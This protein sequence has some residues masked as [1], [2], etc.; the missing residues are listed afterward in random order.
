VTRRR[1]A[2]LVPALLLLAFPLGL[3]AL[4]RATGGPAPA[5]GKKPLT[6]EAVYGEPP[7]VSRPASGIAWR[8]ARR[9]TFVTRDGSGPEAPETLWQVDA[10][11]GIKTT[12]LS[13]PELPAAGPDRKPMPLSLDR[14]RWN[15]AGT[16]ILLTAD[17][18]LW[19]RRFDA[20]PGEALKRLTRDPEP[21]E[22]AQFSPDGSRVA[23][24]KKN[25]L[26][27]VDVATGAEKRLTTTGS[28]HLLNGK[29]DWVYEEELANRRSGR[30]FEWAPDGKSIAYL[31]LD[32]NRVPEYPIV[33]DLPTDAKLTRQ[34]YPKA[35][36]PNPAPSVH[37]VDL[38][39]SETAS[40]Q[41]DP[42][43]VLIAPEFSWTPDATSVVF[44]QL[45]RVQTVL[46]FSLLP[47]AGGRPKLLLR[48]SDP[49]W[50]NHLEPPRFLKDGSGFLMVS[51]RTGFA[52]LYRYA[53]DGTLRNAVTRGGWMVDGPWDVDEKTGTAF[54]VSTEKDP[55]ERQVYS[56]RLDGTSERRLTVEEGTHGL[57]LS[58]GGRWFVSTFS[59]L[60]TP[61][62][63]FLR[64]A[65]GSVAALLDEPANRLAEYELP[66]TEL[67]SFRGTDGTLFYTSLT[68]PP[69]FDPARKYPVLVYVYGG[70]HAQEVRNAWARPSVDTVLA[71]KGIL[72]WTMD[73]RGS[74]GRGHAFET[75]VLRNLGTRELADQLEGTAE[76]KKRPYVDG[77]RI[78]IH[79]WSYGGYLTLFAA[80]HAGELF[81]SAAAGAPV[82]DW[83]FYDSI[84]TERYMKLP[85][86]NVEGY[87]ASS[88]VEAAG[89]L[90]TRLLIL[91]GT[92]D[93]NVH[94]QNTMVFADALMKARKDYDFVPLPRQPHGPRDPAAR[95]Y[96][97]QRIAELFEETLLN[98]PLKTPREA[99]RERA[100]GL[101]ES[102]DDV[103]KFSMIG[104]LSRR[105]R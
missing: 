95:L 35:G 97:N 87:K 90:G 69:G 92:S 17:S 10:E 79:G 4:T 82:T 25:D 80:T 6:L 24:V 5:A 32:E 42:D 29:L 41:P 72:V 83:K 57:V 37:V 104:N 20:A 13:K 22:W 85:K 63:T 14:Y 94:L 18:D 48:E 43:D 77:S 93:D 102:C 81:R 53:M 45:D 2:G 64:K 86:D 67:G 3:P 91:H 62:K 38:D 34:R 15:S 50:I 47:R 16:A 89:K 23:Y 9:A 75:P 78:G 74:W 59:S 99:A 40:Y 73:N 71:A 27:S 54:Y 66:T 58:P 105:H 28:G 56:V 30:S 60:T 49:A 31:R 7:L 36:D 52:H 84:Y 65:D 1:P 8:D 101:A 44:G 55:R 33:D 70:P 100:G 98:Q 51:E 103:S 68:K 19:I 39:G 96:A 88:P 26:W 12:L 76:L 21:E 11:T 61:P 46:A